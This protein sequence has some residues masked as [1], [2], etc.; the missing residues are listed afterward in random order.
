MERPR[1]GIT[2]GN[3]PLSP[4]YVLLSVIV[5]LAGGRPVRLRPLRAGRLRRRGLRRAVTGDTATV[6]IG[7]TPLNRPFRAGLGFSHP[8]VPLAGIVLTGGPNIS[9]TLL[10]SLSNATHPEA[11][12]RDIL[13]LDLARRARNQALP[14]LGICRGAQIVS[15]A[16]EGSLHESVRTAYP[17]AR[18]PHHPL[19]Y[20][21]FRKRIRV[22][23]GSLLR[24]LVDSDLLWVNSLHR[25]AIDATG[26]GLRV[27]A[28]EDN[29][30]VQAV[31]D[32]GHPFY[33]GVQF[34][35]ELLVARKPFRRI[36]TGLVELARRTQTA[37]D[38]SSP[39]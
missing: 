38:L 24:R 15:V 8:E 4:T 3:A 34:H 31:E 25:Q 39:R 30:V 36:F 27:V 20:A 11:K 9:Q 26:A 5:V 21:L 7:R 2:T 1:I 33:L 12:A 14:L 37:D 18:Y 16:G 10:E 28:T 19:G 6:D 35:P 22:V 13:E 32:P 17:N 23:P 29:G